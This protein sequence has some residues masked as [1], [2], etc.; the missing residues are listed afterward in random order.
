MEMNLFFVLKTK[1]EIF[2]VRDKKNETLKLQSHR[3]LHR[4]NKIN[5]S[6]LYSLVISNKLRNARLITVPTC[7]TT[8]NSSTF[9][10]R[11]FRVVV[12][13]GTFR[14]FDMFKCLKLRLTQS[15]CK[16]M[17]LSNYCVTC[18]KMYFYLFKRLQ[19]LLVFIQPFGMLP[20]Q[21]VSLLLRQSVPQIFLFLF[22]N[23]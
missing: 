14:S 16:Q 3:R 6:H 11:L 8:Q 9:I 1:R 23:F 22:R 12:G 18:Q 17:Q 13:N 19:L 10:G 7:K 2:R 4:K 5:R 21:L 15:L 20:F